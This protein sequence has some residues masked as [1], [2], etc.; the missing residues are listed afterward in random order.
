MKNS[1]GLIILGVVCV[2]LGIWS[3]T[4]TK[5]SATRQREDAETIGTLSNKW[6]KS[7]ADL[8]EQRQVTTLLEK[9]L[10]TQKKAVSELSNTFT[11]VSSDLNRAETSLA[12]AKKD[13]AQRDSKIAELENQNQALDKQAVD[14]STAITNLNMEI[15]QTQRKLAASEG[16]K[17]FLERELKRMMSEKSEL[18][19]QFNDLTVLRAQV[20]KIK[21]EI[22]VAR[23]IDWMRRGLYASTEQKGAQRL[24]QTINPPGPQSPKP[25]YDLNVEVSADGSVKVI[26][27]V[28]NAPATKPPVAR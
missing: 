2:G 24:M 10:D 6:V 14:L 16:D 28:T 26:P 4:V 8:V 5:N 27:A 18:E 19:R 13:L 3:I 11:Q 20:A 12:T 21:D 23:R 9:D 7:D 22:A 25:N 15:A 17:S 1:A